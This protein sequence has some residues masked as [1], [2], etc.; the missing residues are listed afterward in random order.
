MTAPPRRSGRRRVPRDAP[1]GVTVAR[2][3]AGAIITIPSD[4]TMV[5]LQSRELKVTLLARETVEGLHD[6]LGVFLER[7]G[8]RDV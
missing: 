3:G 7:R 8:S 1:A 5:L 2:A 6:A 4:V